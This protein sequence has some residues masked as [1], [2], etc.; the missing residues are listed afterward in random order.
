MLGRRLYARAKPSLARD[1]GR[2]GL[3]EGS[4]SQLGR[5]LGSAEEEGSK[6]WATAHLMAWGL[7]RL[8][9][10]E[11]LSL[12]FDES[13]DGREARAQKQKGAWLGVVVTFAL[14]G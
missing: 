14:T 6:P 4:R 8:R 11:G 3:D 12:A 2:R 7:G 5:K 13:N 1:M 9:L 10:R